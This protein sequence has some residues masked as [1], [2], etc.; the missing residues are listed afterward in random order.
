MNES[1]NLGN[2]INSA[3]SSNKVTDG[4]FFNMDQRTGALSIFRNMDGRQMMPILHLLPSWPGILQGEELFELA[5]V[6]CDELSDM[7]QRDSP[8]ED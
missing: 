4:F 6:V 5:N 7:E 8:N 2:I 1:S 3:N